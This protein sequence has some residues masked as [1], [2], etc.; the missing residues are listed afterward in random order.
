MYRVADS[1]PCHPSSIPLGEKK[2]NKRK[3]A[4]IGPFKKKMHAIIS[5]CLRLTQ[6]FLEMVT[7]LIC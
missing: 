6:V 4:G 7:F 2:E 1:G 3:E 5:T